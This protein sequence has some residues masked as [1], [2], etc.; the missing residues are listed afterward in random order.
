MSTPRNLPKIPQGQDS[1]PLDRASLIKAIRHERTR[2]KQLEKAT[3]ELSLTIE[4][5]KVQVLEV[6]AHIAEVKKGI[7][8]ELAQCSR[9]EHQY[10]AQEEQISAFKN[11]EDEQRKLTNQLQKV[12]AKLKDHAR[13]RD[14]EQLSWEEY[15]SYLKANVNMF[16]QELQEV[17]K[18]E[19]QVNPPVSKD[20]MK[21][22]A[23]LMKEMAEL[24]DLEE[25]YDEQAVNMKQSLEQLNEEIKKLEELH[26]QF[27]S[28]VDPSSSSNHASGADTSGISNS[29]TGEGQYAQNPNAS[30]SARLKLDEPVSPDTL[31]SDFAPPSPSLGFPELAPQSHWDVELEALV[32]QNQAIRAYIDRLLS[33]IVDLDEFQIVLHRDFDSLVGEGA[34]E[35]PKSSTT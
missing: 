18:Q 7:D 29:R 20:F 32:E 25:E 24:R 30:A 11:A 15:E 8:Q 27:S 13:I 21:D 4:E 12:K 2:R 34:S 26:T 28:L 6:D 35:G 16:S 17:M 10:Q 33:R 23:Q 19:D 1:Q 22:P 3:S 14:E 31:N 9:L 5:R